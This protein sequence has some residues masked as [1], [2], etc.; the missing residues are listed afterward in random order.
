MKNELSKIGV[1][2][3]IMDDSKLRLKENKIGLDHNNIH[4]IDTYNDHRMAMAFLP[5]S[6]I[7]N[8]IKIENPEVVN[9]SY[10][11]FW[12]DLV[13]VGFTIKEDLNE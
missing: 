6:L 11:A 3:E 5:L 2:V 10:P 1:S 4:I 13:S 9:K 7:Y 8:E 12:D